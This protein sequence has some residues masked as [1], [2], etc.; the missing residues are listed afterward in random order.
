MQA[1][2]RSMFPAVRWRRWRLAALDLGRSRSGSGPQAVWTSEAITVAA[3]AA[4]AP[5]GYSS[6]SKRAAARR[7]HDCRSV[8]SRR[9]ALSD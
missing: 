6:G 9:R 4:G 5:D 7:A 1:I 3:L 2:C 8:C